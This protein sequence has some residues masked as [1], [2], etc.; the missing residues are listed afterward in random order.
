MHEQHQ[1]IQTQMQR[2]VRTHCH[3]L[4]LHLHLLLTHVSQGSANAR[5]KKKT[6]SMTPW[7]SEVES[8]IAYSILDE[9]LT[10]SV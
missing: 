7:P 1:H 8:K 9:K 3:G 6:G 5:I 2:Q 10:K 4:D